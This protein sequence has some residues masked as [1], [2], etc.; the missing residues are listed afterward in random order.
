LYGRKERKVVTEVIAK[1]QY[2]EIMRT[3]VAHASKGTYELA[4]EIV[5]MSAEVYTDRD[6]WDRERERIFRRLP[7][8]AAAS[9]EL[10]KPGDYKA[11]DL[12]EVPVLMVRGS[13]GEV[14]AYLNSC[15]HRGAQVATPGMGNAKRFTCLYHGWTYGQKGELLAV[16]AAPDFGDVDKKCLGLTELPCAERAGMIFVTLNSQA[17]V[18]IDAYL[19]GFDKHI[20]GLGMKG[21]HF[22]RSTPIPGPNWK[23]AMEG[24]FDYYHLPVLHK[25][26]FVPLLS[27]GH[28]ALYWD[29]GPHLRTTNPDSR[30]SFLADIPEEDWSLDKV[31]AGGFTLFPCATITTLRRGNV[32]GALIMQIL[33]GPTVGTSITNQ[34]FIVQ[35]EPHGEDLKVITEW[36]DLNLIAVRDED[37]VASASQQKMLDT[38]LLDKV[39][40]GRNERG[41]QLFHQWVQTIIDTDDA[42]LPTLFQQK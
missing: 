6:R 5:E 36:I 40:F 14:R 19:M 27:P 12:V 33:P 13:D 1:D 21:W 9:C 23:L 39:R 8:M 41:S 18:D 25:E 24:T 20:E 38:G 7:L 28:R 17:K 42:A 31:L 10:P 37:Y 22:M 35:E 15:K 11:M 32:I 29:F 2:A 30:L 4:D 3:T 16:A 34:C 26:T